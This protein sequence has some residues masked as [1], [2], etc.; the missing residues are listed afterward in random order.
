RR[1]ARLR[2][3]PAAT[4]AEGIRRS[5]RALPRR[6]RLALRGGHPPTYDG[7]ALDPAEEEVLDKQADDHDGDQAGE[8]QVRVHL[9]PVLVDEPAEPG[10]APGDAED[11]LRRDHRA[12]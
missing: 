10:V 7:V 12:P 3:L 11:H 2:P 5:D 9:E 1:A 8:D 4:A 6:R